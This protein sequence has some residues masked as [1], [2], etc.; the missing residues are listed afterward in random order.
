[1]PAHRKQI[2]DVAPYQELLA[3]IIAILGSRGAPLLI[4]DFSNVQK[5]RR[6]ATELCQNGRGVIPQRG[7]TIIK[8]NRNGDTPTRAAA[9][10]VLQG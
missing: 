5:S 1:M 9:E 6:S 3:R 10:N 7:V 2:I 8:R 4:A